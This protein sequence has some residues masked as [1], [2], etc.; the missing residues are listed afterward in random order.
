MLIDESSP[1]S[2]SFQDLRAIFTITNQ[3]TATTDEI[4]VVDAADD[5]PNQDEE[6][7]V[8]TITQADATEAFLEAYDDVLDS[9][10]DV[11]VAKTSSDTYTQPTQNG[12]DP[13]TDAV[14]LVDEN[15][16][17]GHTYYVDMTGSNIDI[18][19]LTTGRY[20]VDNAAKGDFADGAGACFIFPG[21]AVDWDLTVGDDTDGY[22]TTTRAILSRYA[23]VCDRGNNRI[24]VIGVPDISTTAGDDLPGDAHTCVAQPSGAG[25]IGA[26]QDQ[27]YRFVT[28]ASVP[29]NWKTGTVARPIKE[30]SLETIIAD[31]DGTPVTW[32]RVD[33]LST[34]GPNDKVFQL[35]WWEGVIL[36]G[37]GVH[38]EIPPAS[39]E[40]EC[41]Y[42]TT[43]DVL[44]YGSAGSGP[45]QFSD[46]TGVCAIWNANLS[47]FVVYVAD[48]GNDRIQKFFFYPEDAALNM[49]PRMEFVCEWS[50][51]SGSGDL[52]SG[53]TDIDVE[54][55]G[56][57]Y[58]VGVVDY[59]NDRVVIYD[60]T[61]FETGGTTV[62]TFETSFG[63][64]GNTL[65]NFASIDGIDLVKNG[66][67]IEIYVADGSRGTV[68]KY[69]LAPMPAIMLV[70]TGASQ[71]PAS[72]PPSGSYPIT[73]T[74]TNAPEGA[75]VDFYYDTSDTWSASSKL[76][77]P[78]GSV[79]TADSPVTW[80]FA[81]SPDGMPADGTY[82]LFAILKDADGNTLAT[83]AST[84][85]ELLTIDS[86]LTQSLQARDQ[87]D[88]DPTLLMAPGQEK[89]IL[90]EVAY[91]DSIVG[92]SFVGTFPTDIME[93]TG[94]HPGNGWEGTGYTQHV[95][96]ATYDNA[97]GTYEVHTAVVGSP[98]GLTAS[99][100]HTLATVTV[101]AKDALDTSTRSM[102][103]VF[104]VD[105]GKSTL[106]DKD[107][108]TP[109]SWE[110][111]SLGV[112][113]AYV[114]DIAN[115]TTGVDST[116]PY[117][118]PRPD[119]Y[120]SSA[121]MFA[122]VFG[123]NGSGGT[124]DPIAD[125]GPTRGKA[126]NLVP[127]PDGE[128]DL[129]DL[130]AFTTNWSWF[131]ANGFGTPAVV[132]KGVVP[133]FT[134]MGEPVEGEAVISMNA[135]VDEP[136]PGN[137]VTVDVEV[138]DVTDLTGAVVR[139]AYDPTETRLLRVEKGEFLERGGASVLMETIQRDGLCEVCLG[140]LSPEAPGV[141]G[142][143]TLATLTFELIAVPES[144]LVFG[145]DL[146]S[147]DNVVL[148]RETSRWSLGGAATGKVALFQNFPN[149]LSNE[150]SIVFS[151][152]KASEVDLSVY[153]LS[154]RKV[155]TLLSGPQDPGVFAVEWNGTDGLGMRVPSGVYFYKL[156]VGETEHTKKMMVAW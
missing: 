107:G 120:M 81:D 72:F 11:Y 126:P 76:C 13:Y 19:D 17:T 37:D 22:I 149:P 83:D 5:S 61:A 59:G 54:T 48:T 14:T 88:N 139:V 34:A 28:P 31:P 130:I 147:N 100:R 2:K 38:G 20:L 12:M 42:T 155:R 18:I 46:P 26:V 50:T 129:D 21:W 109:S 156:R 153:D 137:T 41:T 10:S 3:T 91:P 25:T 115:A 84:S 7:M 122:F 97:A 98:Y 71:L 128:W 117:Q 62:P 80:V 52:L 151:L 133:G 102:S 114:G 123:W 132:G 86:N 94:I 53:P 30:G 95:W 118:Q 45:G 101:R 65:G 33:D 136:L 141:S 152:P 47:C 150:T 82:Y 143:G 29:E 111:R 1:T 134:P 16:V 125:M 57:D 110:A 69:V 104:T 138:S 93:I 32:T 8:Y 15:Q 35:D 79:G 116:V 66:T 49:P 106:T 124:R 148:L 146:R 131:E 75:Y 103:G 60:D 121:D 23:F 144:E 4:W 127:A 77:F 40:F 55:D 87:F 58:Y 119:G 44:R 63:G 89:T 142:E 9:P 64:T 68:T 108:N 70:F 56:T 67:E 90:L 78:S 6:L 27:D 36:F 154:G 51:A 24:K 85:T 145:Y 135:C 92:A 105:A 96:S 43:P 73:F 39:T 99:G 74:V 112:Y 140:R 113:L